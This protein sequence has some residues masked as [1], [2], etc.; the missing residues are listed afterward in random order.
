VTTL[1]RAREWLTDALD[2]A[3]D[4]AAR[5]ASGDDCADQLADAE[6]EREAW[7]AAELH[8]IVRSASVDQPP[9]PGPG[10]DPN[11]EV[12]AAAVGFYDCLCGSTTTFDD[13]DGLEE[14]AALNRW[15]GR[16]ESC[17][18]THTK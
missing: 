9:N 14:Y 6:A 10:A 7:A 12:F 15:L 17:H 13:T 8:P 18:E 3:L 5:T 16:H 2:G 11:P 1:R 4:G